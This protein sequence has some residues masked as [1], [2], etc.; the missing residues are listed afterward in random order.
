MFLGR[1]GKID[2]AITEFERAVKY[3]PEF[4]DA[5]YDLANAFFVKNDF[6]NAKSHYLATLRARSKSSDSL[7][8]I[9]ASFFCA[10]GK[11]RKRSSSSMK[12]CA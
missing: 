6:E 2:E 9:S 4:A 5:H 11:F 8:S 7:Q 3:K 10:R 12:R 1:E